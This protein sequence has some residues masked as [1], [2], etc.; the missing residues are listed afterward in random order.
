MKKKTLP[1]KVVQHPVPTECYFK[2]RKGF[3]IFISSEVWWH[4]VKDKTYGIDLFM[5][6]VDDPKIASDI[7]WNDYVYLTTGEFHK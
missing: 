4:Y 3:L 1:F 6:Y 5:G 7:L 2:T